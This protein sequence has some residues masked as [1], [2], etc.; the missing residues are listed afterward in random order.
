MGPAEVIIDASVLLAILLEEAEGPSFK[1]LVARSA[2]EHVMSPM[3]YLEAA[4][5]VDR[6]PA[7]DKS[8][9]LDPLMS[10]LDIRIAPTTAEQARLAREAYLRFGKGS[11]PAK[12]N[13]GVCF[14]YALAKARNEPLLF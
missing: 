14:A 8:V 2:G 1:M 5:R 13:L 4:V 11:H 3:N 10:A 7:K 9:Q 6:F 12:L